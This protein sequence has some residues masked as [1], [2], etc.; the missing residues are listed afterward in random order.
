MVTYLYLIKYYCQLI[1]NLQCENR[2]EI[3]IKCFIVYA[4]MTF[5][6]TNILLTESRVVILL[7]L[8]GAL[9]YIILDKEN[10]VINFINI[11]ISVIFGVIFTNIIQK[12][13]YINKENSHPDQGVSFFY[14]SD[15]MD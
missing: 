3:Q 7:T 1:I 13:M 5:I 6:F 14:I 4:L 8:I 15:P 9:I 11:L 12:N 2:N 10:K